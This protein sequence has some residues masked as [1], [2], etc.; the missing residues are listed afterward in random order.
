M[1]KNVP[2]GAEIVLQREIKIIDGDGYYVA[3]RILADGKIIDAVVYAPED[4]VP[5]G[6]MI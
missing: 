2:E 3:H 5:C 4:I 1:W 6:Y